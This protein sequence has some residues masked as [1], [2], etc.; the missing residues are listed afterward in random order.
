MAKKCIVKTREIH[1]GLLWNLAT[2]CWVR[3]ICYLIRIRIS[4][5]HAANFDDWNNVSCNLITQGED[6]QQLKLAAV[7][8]RPMGSSQSDKHSNP[9]V[10]IMD[11][12]QKL[13]KRVE[14]CNSAFSLTLLLLFN[15]SLQTMQLEQSQLQQ[16][17]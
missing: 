12:E 16:L 8:S 10:T 9:V 1:Q 13:R 14:Y 6:Q 11:L 7:N 4:F 2:D 17:Q 3:K 15:L 5:Y